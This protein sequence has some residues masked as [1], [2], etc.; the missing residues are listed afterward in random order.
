MT[1]KLE[2]GAE[3]R[4][5]DATKSV[6][7]MVRCVALVVGNPWERCI[8]CIPITKYHFR[9][10]IMAGTLSLSGRYRGWIWVP[11]RYKKMRKHWRHGFLC[12][13]LAPLH[14]HDSPNGEREKYQSIG[15]V[16]AVVSCPVEFD[17]FAW[18][19]NGLF[20]R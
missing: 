14:R 4:T 19:G 15:M 16:P 12:H 20:C 9:W 11:S 1:I 10:T 17:Q 18:D 3:K 8:C 7:Y 5:V 6:L 2:H 13:S